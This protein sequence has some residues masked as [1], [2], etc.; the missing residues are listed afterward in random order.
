[1]DRSVS[2]T[3]ALVIAIA[4]LTVAIVLLVF[5][6]RTIRAVRRERAERVEAERAQLELELLAAEQGTRM[7]IV[8]ELNELAVHS[9]SSI[10]NHAEGAQY[11]AATDP[12][13]AVR[14]TKTIGESARITLADLRRVV[15]VVRDGEAAA[16]PQPRLSSVREL[17]KVMRDAGLVIEFTETGDRLDLRQAVE[18]AIYR[19]LQEALSNALLHGGE[20]THVRVAF[21]WKGPDLE[22][23][24]DDDG[25]R[26]AAR[27]KGKDPDDPDF[28]GETTADADLA[29]LTQPPA[30]RGITEMRERTELFG[31]VFTARTIPGVGF[32]ISAVFPG[33][34]HQTGL[35]SMSFDRPR[36]ATTRH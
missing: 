32:S 6:L 8:R 9:L 22:L 23:L 3:V 24:V 1:M 29:A 36:D 4:L 31:G 14:A 7:R 12:G 20:G 18:L 5:W 25:A 17:F 2:L 16:G 13:A 21:S 34:Q 27:R 30:G 26:T 28:Q 15:D 11:A 10:A 35:H 33:I 19:I